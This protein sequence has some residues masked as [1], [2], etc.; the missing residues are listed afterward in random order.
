MDLCPLCEEKY[1]SLG[2]HW[3]KGCGYPEI[4]TETKEI[5]RGLLLGDAY[6]NEPKSGNS[7]LILKV[8]NEDFCKWVDKNLGWLSCGVSKRQSAAEIA[9]RFDGAT[10]ESVLGPAYAVTTRRHPFFNSLRKW[11]SSG[12]KRF[13]DDLKLTSTSAC[14]WYVCDGSLHQDGRAQI[15]SH[16][17]S[18]RSD[19]LISLFKEH[20]FNPNISGSNI[21]FSVDE[22][23]K[24]LEWVG[25]PV[26][27]YEYKWEI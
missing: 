9:E 22:T 25:P 12:S 24:F 27:G 15:F 21:Y 11:Y 1:S 23:P 10:E 7:R 26:K 6:I 19:Y 3:N 18:D 14:M 8:C 13:P 5:L 17:E 2:M 20:E 16:D 4:D